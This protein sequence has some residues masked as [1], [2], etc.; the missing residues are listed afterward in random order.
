VLACINEGELRAPGEPCPGP[1]APG[2][3]GRRQFADFFIGQKASDL[4]GRHP[5]D[6]IPATNRRPAPVLTT[7]PCRISPLSSRTR[8]SVPKAR[9]DREIAGVPFFSAVW[10]TGRPSSFTAHTPCGI[11]TLGDSSWPYVLR[12]AGTFAYSPQRP[13]PASW[14][15]TG[16]RPCGRQKDLLSELH[17]GDIIVRMSPGEADH[18]KLAFAGRHQPAHPGALP[19][20]TTTHSWIGPKRGWTRNGPRPVVAGDRRA[21]SPCAA[22]ACALQGAVAFF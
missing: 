18:V 4:R 10:A 1:N 21:G 7:M 8:S 11:W 22:A 3:R 9:P 20:K 19:P 12:I 14:Q 2:G 6:A 13:R 15:E 16:Q 5:L 17:P